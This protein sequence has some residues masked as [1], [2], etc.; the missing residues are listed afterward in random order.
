VSSA[1]RHRADCRRGR[2]DDD[3]GECRQK[4]SGSSHEMP[5]WLVDRLRTDANTLIREKIAKGLGPVEKR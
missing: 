3:D 1:G 2:R 5:C 4:T